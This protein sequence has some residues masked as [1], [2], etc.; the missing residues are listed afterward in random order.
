MEV[1]EA[2]CLPYRHSRA[3]RFLVPCRQPLIW[4]AQ[5]QPEVLLV[6]QLRWHRVQGAL[7]RV[8][9][10]FCFCAS[11]DSS[12]K[13]RFR[14]RSA[15]PR[16]RVLRNRRCPPPGCCQAAP[17]RPSQ[18]NMLSRVLTYRDHRRCAPR[19]MPDPFV[20]KQALPRPLPEATKPA[21]PIITSFSGAMTRT[22]GPPAGLGATPES[23]DHFPARLSL[24][25]LLPAAP[26]AA[27]RGSVPLFRL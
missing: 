11:C 5:L 20:P 6:L 7:S 24:L 17:P 13:I 21:P 19:R 23:Q 3:L 15:P 22:R 8:S 14:P 9:G 26:R 1:S 16:E 27:N 2:N 10:S 12:M 18:T 4:S 25:D